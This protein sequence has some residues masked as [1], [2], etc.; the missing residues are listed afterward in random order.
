MAVLTKVQM[1]LRTALTIRW[2]SFTYPI[3]RIPVRWLHRVLIGRNLLSLTASGDNPK[4]VADMRDYE[5]RV[6][7]EESCRED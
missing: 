6:T 5:M 4:T 7:S 3:L 1:V 2:L